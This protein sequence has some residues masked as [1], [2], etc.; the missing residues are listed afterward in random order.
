MADENAKRIFDYSNG[1]RTNVTIVGRA[2]PVACDEDRTCAAAPGD[3]GADS[4]RVGT[5]TRL[6]ETPPVPGLEGRMT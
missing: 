5:G 3:T 6:A 2:A 1:R 4:G